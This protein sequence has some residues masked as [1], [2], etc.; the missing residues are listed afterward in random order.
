[1]GSRVCDGDK[2]PDEIWAILI[3][4][5]RYRGEPTRRDTIRDRRNELAANIS[6][7]Q[8][9]TFIGKMPP[10]Y[11]WTKQVYE[12]LGAGDRIRVV[13]SSRDWKPVAK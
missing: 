7:Q 11:E 2:P 1:M 12:K 5:I 9:I 3:N 13:R 10:A 6:F 4:P 8:E